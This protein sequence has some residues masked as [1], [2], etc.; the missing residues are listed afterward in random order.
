MTTPERLRKRQLR[1]DWFMAFLAVTLA[2]SVWFFD[3]RDDGLIA[4]FSDYIAADSETGSIRSGLV[5]RDSDATRAVILKAG[6]ATTREEF[7]DAINEANRE[8]MAV[9]KAR[10]ENPVK[11]FDPETDC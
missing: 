1:N 8:W 3:R 7:L 6:S 11:P 9:D 4:C 5:E 2:A 10:A